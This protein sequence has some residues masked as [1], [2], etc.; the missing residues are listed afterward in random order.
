MHQRLLLFILLCSAF[1]LQAQQRY[2][3][4][5]FDSVIISQ[6]N[7]YG[8][9]ISIV[10]AAPALDSLFFDIYMP[11]GDTL[12]ERPVVLVLHTGTFLP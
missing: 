9:N 8:A 4:E 10:T 2:V 7:L 11:A 6:D 1:T 5:V 12:T 3:D